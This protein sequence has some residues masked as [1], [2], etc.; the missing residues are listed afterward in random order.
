VK[1]TFSKLNCKIDGLG[2]ADFKQAEILNKFTLPVCTKEEAKM[3]CDILKSW[4]E[5]D[6]GD[7]VRQSW[8]TL[9]G[10]NVDAEVLQDL[11]AMR[12]E[13]MEIS[14]LNSPDS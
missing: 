3:D 12:L 1:E 14:T 4:L 2:L 6:D 9:C 13:L 5:W 8:K 11:Q 7:L 10:G